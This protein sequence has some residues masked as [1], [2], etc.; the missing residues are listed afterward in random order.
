MEI[1]PIRIIS[2]TRLN[3]KI[4]KISQNACPTYPIYRTTSRKYN[5]LARLF[6]RYFS[7]I[8]LERV[9]IYKYNKVSMYGKRERENKERKRYG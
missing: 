7:P 9:Y 2:F 3:R 8:E 1:S 4:T 5:N 6:P